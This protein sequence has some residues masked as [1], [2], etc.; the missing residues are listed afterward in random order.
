MQLLSKSFQFIENP[1]PSREEINTALLI[2]RVFVALVFISF[3]Y[4]KLFGAPGIEGFTGM[5]TML[6]FPM[7]AV[8]AYLVGIA[9]LFGGIAIL[10]GVATRFSAF[11]LAIIS[12]AAWVQVKGLG[13]GMLTTLPNGDPFAG[14]VVDALAVG[15][16]LV[17]FVAGPGGF[18]VSAQ[19]AS[20]QSTEA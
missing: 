6:S 17:L 15:L 4:G 19:K 18:S 1:Q 3:G 9:E 5:L 20:T 14:G 13:L 10:L 7:P 8:F 2:A 16:V 12:L 11:W